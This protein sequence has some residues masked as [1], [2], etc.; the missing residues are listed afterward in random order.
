MKTQVDLAGIVMKNPVMT[1]SGTFGH[2]EN[3]EQFFD[4]N[5]LGAIVPKS[6]TLEP[7]K[8]NP[9]PNPSPP[10]FAMVFLRNLVTTGP[11]T[12]VVVRS[13]HVIRA[14]LVDD[15]NSHMYGMR[16]PFRPIDGA[17]SS[18]WGLMGTAASS[19][20]WDLVVHCGLACHDEPR[21]NVHGHAGWG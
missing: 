16:Q 3:Y 9:P 12:M 18:L 6:V 2:G 4:L 1:A 8:G 17:L 10:H 7:R 21:G 19:R 13:L 5:R 14:F 11:G 20:L 15:T